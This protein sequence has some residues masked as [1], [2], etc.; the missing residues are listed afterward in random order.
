MAVIFNLWDLAIWFAAS[1]L[2]MLVA[3]E[4]FA[5]YFGKK[6]LIIDA[7]KLRMTGILFSL[8][9]LFTVGIRVITLT[10]G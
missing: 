4:L 5:P 3:S 6:A 8:A 1:S 9:F 10:S 7:K 2:V